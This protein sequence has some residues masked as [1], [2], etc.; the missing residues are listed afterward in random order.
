MVE[1]GEDSLI[2][3]QKERGVQQEEQLLLLLVA[4]MVVVLSLRDENCRAVTETITG[5]AQLHE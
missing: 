3:L 2:V 4:V 5:A 1:G